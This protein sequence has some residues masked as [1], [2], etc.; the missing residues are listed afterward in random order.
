MGG[1]QKPAPVKKGGPPEV[2]KLAGARVDELFHDDLRILALAG[3]TT[4]D[5]IRWATNQMANAVN[6]AWSRGTCPEGTLPSMTI[7]VGPPKEE[8]QVS[9]GDSNAA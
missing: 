8:P 7:W 2:G 1:A 6:A 4:T 9:E 3:M 5:A